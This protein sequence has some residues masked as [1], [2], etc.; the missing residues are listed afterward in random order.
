VLGVRA[1]RYIGHLGRW[2]DL[3][4]TSWKKTWCTGMVSKGGEVRGAKRHACGRSQQAHSAS[5][6]HK[7]LVQQKSSHPNWKSMM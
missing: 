4:A 2:E 7:T 5:T 3:P 1:S 6:P